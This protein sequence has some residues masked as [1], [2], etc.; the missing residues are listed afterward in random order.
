MIGVSER[1]QRAAESIESLS[2]ERDDKQI[3]VVLGE[4]RGIQRI[5]CSGADPAASKN[6]S[7]F[8][9]V[10][11]AISGIPVTFA[12]VLDADPENGVPEPIDPLAFTDDT[13][14]EQL[15]ELRTL[16]LDSLPAGEVN[17]P[18]TEATVELR[19]AA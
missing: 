7:A 5:I 9:K 18:T 19:E 3:H 13:L 15:A 2:A 14:L 11:E 17:N 6:L 12:P 10:A 1:M 8:E 16:M 4:L